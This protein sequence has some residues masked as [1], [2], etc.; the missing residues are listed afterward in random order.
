MFTIDNSNVHNTQY[1]TKYYIANRRCWQYEYHFSCKCHHFKK[2]FHAYLSAIWATHLG[3]KS[4]SSIQFSCWT[5]WWGFKTWLRPDEFTNMGD[6]I[7]PQINETQVFYIFEISEGG[8]DP[9]LIIVQLIYNILCLYTILV[10]QGTAL[11][12]SITN[13]QRNDP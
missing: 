9:L 8:G 7:L 2:A 13:Y 5:F 11:I 10:F 6:S 12:P 1:N 4:H 3:N